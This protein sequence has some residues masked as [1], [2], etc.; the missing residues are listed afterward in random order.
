LLD[1]NRK[2]NNAT[3]VTA[4][5]QL[6]KYTIVPESLLGSGPRKT[7][8]VLLE[9]VFSKWSVSRLYHRTDRVQFSKCSATEYNGVK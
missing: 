7:M 8:E 6:R 9:A 2:I 1:N 4:R 5:Q 3:M